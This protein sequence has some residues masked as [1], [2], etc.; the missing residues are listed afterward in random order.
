[1]EPINIFDKE[2]GTGLPVQ[3]E[4]IGRGTLDTVQPQL[5]FLRDQYFTGDGKPWPESAFADFI[6]LPLVSG[7]ALGIV[8]AYLEFQKV[9]PSETQILRCVLDVHNH[10]VGN[11]LDVEISIHY[12]MQQPIFKF[13]LDVGSAD[14]RRYLR[15][16]KQAGRSQ[17]VLLTLL[18]PLFLK[19]S[20]AETLKLNL[21]TFSSHHGLQP[22]ENAMWT[23]I[24]DRWQ[25]HK[26]YGMR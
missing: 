18:C 10:F 20:D 25:V 21:I 11:D 19:Y 12:M 16:Q 26:E 2:P 14:V 23:E 4:N 5:F 9:T 8:G 24:I 22:R 3:I 7:Y 1:V 13:G 17:Y 6:R 15:E